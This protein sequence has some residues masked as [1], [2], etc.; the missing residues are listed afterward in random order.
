[1]KSGSFVPINGKVRLVGSSFFK[2]SSIRWKVSF[3]WS[4]LAALVKL[5]LDRHSC[6]VGFIL[7][8]NLEAHFY[9]QLPPAFQ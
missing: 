6:I 1:M 5:G 2:T 7:S 8:D 3:F 4:F 9:E